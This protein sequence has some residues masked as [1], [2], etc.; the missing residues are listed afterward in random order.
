MT[1]HQIYYTLLVGNFNRFNTYKL[2]QTT[3]T[4]HTYDSIIQI[5]ATLDQQV[6]RSGFGGLLVVEKA[7]KD[8]HTIKR[9]SK[10]TGQTPSDG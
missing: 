8:E 2:I 5:D 7:Y 4:N 1:P 9:G 3:Q 10:W 6:E